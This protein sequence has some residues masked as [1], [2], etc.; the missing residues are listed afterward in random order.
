MAR[1][2]W[3]VFLTL[4]IQQSLRCIDPQ[5]ANRQAQMRTTELSL[6]DRLLTILDVDG[7][8][9]ISHIWFTLNSQRAITLNVSS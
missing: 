2:I 7:P 6:L 8:G 5:A 3:W 1:K 9:R 4:T